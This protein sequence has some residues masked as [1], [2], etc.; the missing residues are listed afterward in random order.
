MTHALRKLTAV[1]V[2]LSV[3]F[4]GEAVGQN[5]NG[6]PYTFFN[7][8]PDNRLREFSTD[9]PDLTEGPF[10]ID[11]GRVQTETDIFNY[12]RSRRDEEGTRTETFLFGATTV[13]IGLTKDTEL[14]LVLQPL[15]AVRT[16]MID[17]ARTSWSAGP[18]VLQVRPKINLFGND[19]YKDPGAVALGV[20]PFVNIPTFRNG[21]GAEHVEGG[22]A[23]PVSYKV[24][25]KVDIG[26][27]TQ[28]EFVKNDGRPGYHAEY[29]NSALVTYQIDSKWS[30][31]MEFYTRFG[32]EGPFGGIVIVG[33]GFLYKI[34]DN[35][36]LDFGVN[37]GVTRAADAINPFIGISKRY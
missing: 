11:P 26:A 3:F 15:N 5:G 17:P 24:S 6:V 1:P 25:D 37:F 12:S 9:R 35:L 16:R 14:G 13:R 34:K 27:M 30:T 23:L 28:I 4:G 33:G 10:T 36:Q 21:V 29:V 8:T 19:T 22:V 7:P 32:N 20:V 2:I 31:Y 18:D